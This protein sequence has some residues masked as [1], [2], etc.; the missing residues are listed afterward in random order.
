MRTSAM[1]CPACSV[2]IRGRFQQALFGRLSPED[3]ELL[4]NYLLADFSIKALAAKT[5]MGY[6]ALRS[7]LDRLIEHYR[8]LLESEDEKRQI[9]ERL[10]RGEISS[11]QAARLLKDI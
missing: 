3:Q 1:E 8:R 7:R 5:G 9:L 10:G 6:A 11:Q 4:E 2:E